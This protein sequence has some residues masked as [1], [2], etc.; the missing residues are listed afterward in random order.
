MLTSDELHARFDRMKEAGLRYYIVKPPKRS[1]LFRTLQEA[2]AGQEEHRSPSAPVTMLHANVTPTATARI[3]LAEDN[4]GNRMLVRAYL[5]GTQYEID[6]AE[7]GALAVNKF[8]SHRYD[9]VLMDMYMPVVDGY[10]ATAAIRK[11]ELENNRPRTPVIA[12]TAAA[13]A[14][15][16]ERSLDAGCDLHVTKPVSKAVLLEVI[17]SLVRRRAE[18]VPVSKPYDVA[19][20]LDDPAL[21]AEV[22]ELFLDEMDRLMGSI[23]TA[24]ADS[25]FKQLKD[26]VH[27]LKGSAAMI[28]AHPIAAV[29]K[30]IEAAIASASMDGVRQGLANLRT[31]QPRAHVVFG[32]KP[33]AI[34]QAS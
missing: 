8:T 14:G 4:P 23:D 6:E 28:G 15:D 26:Y 24:F 32:K 25:N 9:V 30:D 1:E 16:R 21:F 18:E 5:K 20:E 3:L 34:A 31:E 22:A 29:C 11:W 17:D 13:M 12:L 10:E 27:S 7:N 2:L 19:A 33:E